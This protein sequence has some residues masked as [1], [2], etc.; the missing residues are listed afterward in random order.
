[1]HDDFDEMFLPTTVPQVIQGVRK[2]NI[3]VLGD[4]TFP[5]YKPLMNKVLTHFPR[6]RTINLSLVEPDATSTNIFAVIF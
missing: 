5:S 2:L 6:L 3:L 1:M 4:G